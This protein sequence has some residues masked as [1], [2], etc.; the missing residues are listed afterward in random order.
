MPAPDAFDAGRLELPEELELVRKLGEF[1]E[2]VGRAA[3]TREPHHIAYFLRDLAGLWNPYIQDGQR[4]RVLS[5]DQSLTAAR[6]GLVLAVRHVLAAGLDV[7]GVS[8][9]EA[10]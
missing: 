4:H 2:L 3:E 1:P 5:D 9:P 8:A 7:L 10:M 6:L